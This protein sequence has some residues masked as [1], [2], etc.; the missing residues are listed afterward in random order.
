VATGA[1]DFRSLDGLGDLGALMDNPVALGA[2][3]GV[4]VLAWW[5]MKRK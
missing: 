4:A 2:I 1:E 5:A 3:T